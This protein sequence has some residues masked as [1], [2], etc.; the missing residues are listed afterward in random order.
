L[1]KNLLSSVESLELWSEISMV[2]FFVVFV[3]VI[4]YTFRLNKSD[5]DYMSQLPLSENENINYKESH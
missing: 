2:I 5:M 4:V 1:F 3:T